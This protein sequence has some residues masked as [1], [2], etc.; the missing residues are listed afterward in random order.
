MRVILVQPRLSVAADE[1]NLEAIID[2]VERA[3]L[4]GPPE[5]D[6][7]LVLPEHWDARLE[8]G[9]Y[10]RAVRQLAR[11]FGCHVVGGSHYGAH[12]DAAINTGVAVAPDGA[13]IGSY[14]KLRPYADERER[15]RPGTRIGEM[16]IAGRRVLVLICADFWFSDLFNRVVHR[17][18]LILVPALSITRKPDPGYSRALWRH[19]AV[20]RAYELGV[21]VGISDWARESPLA[22]SAAGVAGFADP[23]T[24]RS[25]R[26][27]P[28]SRRRGRPGVPDRFRRARPVSRRT[29]RARILLARRI[30]RIAVPLRLSHPPE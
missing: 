8:P 24:V 19:L 11:R 16:T 26:V 29:H 7:I 12:G 13:V 27:L 23:V 14:D 22:L 30:A 6:D 20:A 18:D 25:G 9:V 2:T 3:E 1:T 28:A 17:P 4:G 21:Y 15:A 10:E 5:P